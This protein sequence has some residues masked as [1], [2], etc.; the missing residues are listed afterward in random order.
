MAYE[1]IKLP[2]DR[3]KL[4]KLVDEHVSRERTKQSLWRTTALLAWYY[5]QGIRNFTV[6]NPQSQAIQ[7]KLVDDEDR[8]EF[9]SMELLKAADRVHGYLNQMDLMPAVKRV[10]ESLSGIRDRA[11][12]Q[13][14][15]DALVN[16]SHVDDVGNR[17]KWIL[18]YL[19]SCGVTS[20]TYD[21]PA[22][23][24][25]G[26][27]QIIH[28]K[29]LLPFPTLGW[30]YTKQSGIV[31]S[32]TVPVETLKD[33]FGSNAMRAE[34]R[35]KMEIYRARPGDHV[36]GLSDQEYGASG[37]DHAHGGGSNTAGRPELMEV[38]RF[39][40]VWLDGPAGTCGRYIAS[41][42]KHLIEDQE[43]RDG[44]MYCPIG[45]SRLMENGG[46]HGL[47]LFHLMFSV[48][49]ELERMLKMMAKTVR[50]VDKYG[51][52]VLPMGA[53]NERAGFR[54]IGK[55]MRI[56]L[57]EP[58]V[59]GTDF[60]PF[61]I[62]PHDAGD[63]PGRTAQFFKGL[64]DQLSPHQDL[65]E[66]KG[67]IDSAPALTLLDERIRS[68][69]SNP[70]NSVARAWG[71]MYRGLQIQASTDLIFSPRALPVSKLTVD[72]AGV[73]IDPEKNEVRFTENTP[74]PK[75]PRL[76]YTIKAASPRSPGTR[77]QEAMQAV[78]LGIATRDDLII[79]ALEEGLDPAINWRAFR[80]PYESVVRNILLLYGNGKDP[81]QIVGTPH[82]AKPEFQLQILESFMTSPIMGM[83]SPA[84][85]D[86]F[87]SY[88]LKLREL[89]G[90]V[91][92]GGMPNPDDLAIL[93]QT[94]QAQMGQER[95]IISQVLAAQNPEQ[96]G[97]LPA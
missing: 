28:P 5:A 61:T 55:D 77:I 94:Q 17:F 18:T 58:D 46:F 8:M 48:N 25:V 26:D 43:F 93:T 21:L 73:V 19:G 78:Q 54:D 38:A 4:A 97:T 75:H 11:I 24:L 31:W 84:V 53:F 42:G 68:S 88:R 6:F 79:L 33:A 69:M 34:N 49:R 36:A 92:V 52:T 2:K 70:T 76:Q 37:A 65:A 82:T 9:T 62:D 90:L 30:D 44:S 85:Q 45:H 47:G 12:S 72:L 14:V 67:R 87:R 27:V 29:E 83:A 13:V 40:E 60:R 23:G 71:A 22:I 51:M 1:R 89:L 63:M 41:S 74:I 3:E 39:H 32:R 20:K 35:Q 7:F 16:A 15:L 10:D 91:L 96:Q 57:Y 81:G 95:N 86:A 50:N 59:T 64:M 66:E 56:L 80:G